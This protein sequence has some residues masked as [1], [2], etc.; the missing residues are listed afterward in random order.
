M[1]TS[2]FGLMSQ[3]LPLAVDVLIKAT[4]LLALV[5][6]AARLFR[7]G[8]AAQRYLLWTLAIVGIV[9]MPVLIA[10]VPFEVP[11]LPAA[12]SSASGN[13]NNGTIRA[14]NT[15]SPTPSPSDEQSPA[16]DAASDPEA[17]ATDHG[18]AAAS[19]SP[20]GTLD[21]ST[22]IVTI[23]LVGA[24]AMLA[25]FVL[26]FVIVRGIAR[27]ATPTTDTGWQSLAD[28]CARS[29]GVEPDTQLRFSHEVEMPFACG[30]ITPVIVLPE[31]SSEWT[32]ERREAV[33]M[34]EFAHISR[35][36]LPMNTFSHFARALYWFHPM[37]W[38]AS[39]R[40]RVE[41][42]RACDDAV[43]RAGALPSDYAEHLLSIVRTVGHS[44][45]NVALAMARRSDFEG[46][47]LA[48]L[49]P[50][51]PRGRLP[52]WRAAAIAAAF[53]VV[54][55]PL[56]AMVP[57]APVGASKVL[58]QT[59]EPASGGAQASEA[60][61]VSAL[62]GSLDDANPVVRVA[63]V[64]SLG[65]LGDPRAIAALA[66]AMREDADPRV[67]EAAAYALGEIDDARAVAPLLEA[68]KNE[69]ASNVRE[70]IIHSLGEIDDPSAVAGIS[71][72]VKDP[73]AAV[74]REAVWAL[75]EFEDPAAVPALLTMV[76][77]DDV[78]VRRHTAE[79][80]G[81]LQ[82][83]A[84]LDALTVLTKDA[85]ADV[86]VE[87]ISA[88]G[89]LEDQRALPALVAALKDA[90]A[91]V[92]TH[93][94]ESIGSLDELKTAPRALIDALSDPNSDVRRSAAEALGNIEDEAAVPG[95]KRLTSDNDADVRRSAAE[96]LSEIGGPDAVQALM[97]LLKDQ[98]PEIRRIAAEALGRK[99]H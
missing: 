94:A 98:D 85:D 59:P 70:K 99:R 63:A 50:G 82:N 88:L 38:L 87:A 46:R 13:T 34:H 18:S 23:W 3:L 17:F 69:K 91:D 14:R 15:N 57:A 37:A 71:A 32:A 5:A 30:L 4:I 1:P 22:L 19:A 90:N 78:E 89:H 54:V 64:K 56:A 45:P 61:A 58:A 80:L 28:R 75:G 24:L 43:L 53:L 42:E 26:G 67:R 68:L 2:T 48:I 16:A 47:L 52:R 40:L 9:A 81:Q 72:A 31:S 27:R 39:H 62:I 84:A 25:R 10:L 77:D 44:V 55:M 86:R 83:L 8:S 93:A 51:I 20:R 92:R 65:A 7:R 41:G 6:G 79:A 35:G 73:S 29:L 21:V 95:L 60:A 11:V 33:L 96:A 12:T 76:R 49:E 97:G 36:D 74:R 66:K